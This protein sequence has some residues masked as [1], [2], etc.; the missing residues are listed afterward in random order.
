MWPNGYY[1]Q[2]QFF[3]FNRWTKDMEKTFV[4]SL[5]EHARS[6]LF[7]PGRSNVHAVMCSLYDVNKRYGTKITYEWA[8]SRVQRLQER[9]HLFRWVVNTEG[10]I[11]N[12]RLGFLTAPDHVWRSLCRQNKRA[13]CYCNAY[14]DFWEELCILFDRP[15][16]GGDED[17]D[18][19][20]VDLN[21][22]AAPEGWVA[23]PP[24]RANEAARGEPA[25]EVGVGAAA[26]IPP[27]LEVA[28]DVEPDAADPEAVPMGPVN[29]AG[30]SEAINEAP[31]NVTHPTNAVPHSQVLIV[32]D[33]SSS[34]M[35]RALEEYYGSDSDADSVLPPPGVPQSLYKRAKVAHPS[36]P[37]ER[38]AGAS[39]STAANA[40]PLKKHT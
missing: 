12:Q 38:S 9:Y 11:W 4:D 19:L 8:Q 1:Y 17:P 13:K 28:P 29:E 22:P 31:H 33:S 36:P 39:S 27:M 21:L 26:E 10:V 23:A 3:Y 37:S 15:N 7:R 14:E 34:S 6:G 5:V 32:S 20:R 30:H 24:P 18:V 40:T 16:N 35:W 2:Q 25:N